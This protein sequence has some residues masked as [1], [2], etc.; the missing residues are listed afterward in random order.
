MIIDYYQMTSMHENPD[1]ILAAGKEI[2]H[3]HFAR[4][5]P[6][7]WPTLQD[8][9]PGYAPFFANIKKIGYRGGISIEAPGTYP[10]DAAPALAFFRKELA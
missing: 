9:D 4:M 6:H 7:G 5:E 8:N 2:V 1:I 10:K 3:F